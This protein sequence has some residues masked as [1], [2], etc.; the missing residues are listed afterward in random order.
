MEIWAG[1]RAMLRAVGIR[2]EACIVT[3]DGED[4]TNVCLALDERAGWARVADLNENGA[5]VYD[6]ETQGVRVKHLTG[7]VVVTNKWGVA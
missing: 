2:P 1:N 5:L 6:P 3:V 7:R 4:V